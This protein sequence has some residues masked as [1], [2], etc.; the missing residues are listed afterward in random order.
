M[1]DGRKRENMKLS[2]CN[3][4]ETNNDTV[5]RDYE[6]TVLSLARPSFEP[7]TKTCT[8]QA[9]D[10]QRAS[11]YRETRVESCFLQE[12][13]LHPPYHLLNGARYRSRVCIL[14]SYFRYER[15]WPLLFRMERREAFLV[16]FLDNIGQVGNI[17]KWLLSMANRA[18]GETFGEIK[19][20]IFVP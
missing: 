15:Q 20:K 1:K 14:H 2:S 9:F 7:L 13:F 3:G 16:F 5:Q 18:R 11:G 10:T 4:K 8:Q 19:G 12:T 17:C 6:E